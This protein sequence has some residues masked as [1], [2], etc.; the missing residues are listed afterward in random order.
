M[1]TRELTEMRKTNALSQTAIEEA[2]TYAQ[3][4][5]KEVLKKQL[6]EQRLMG[7]KEKDTLLLQVG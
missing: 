3:Q 2:T 4:N 5:A 6:E 1:L 7:E